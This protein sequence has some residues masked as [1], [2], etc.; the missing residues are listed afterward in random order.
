MMIEEWRTVEGYEQYEVS[1]TG[2]VRSLN[3]L[4]WG[5]V[6]ELTPSAYKNHLQLNLWANGKQHHAWVHRLVA[7][8]FIPN[9]MNLPEVNHIDGNPRNNCVENLEWCTREGNLAHMHSTGLGDNGVSALK[10]IAINKRKA[11]IAI[12]V[13]S[14]EVQHFVSIQEAGRQLQIPATKICRCLKGK[15]LTSYGWMFKYEE[16]E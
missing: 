7:Q 3:Y 8:A 4:G 13:S 10:E 5:K 15:A 6:K 12:S 2:K 9:P 16:E 14:G 11:V 1:N